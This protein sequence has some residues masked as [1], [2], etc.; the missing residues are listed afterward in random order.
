MKKLSRMNDVYSKDT[1]KPPGMAAQ[2]ANVTKSL[3]L[4]KKNL[5]SIREK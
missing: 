3:I 2:K 5:D 4:L 1:P